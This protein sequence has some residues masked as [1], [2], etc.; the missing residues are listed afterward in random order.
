INIYRLL[1][2][3]GRSAGPWIGAP[4]SLSVQSA[5]PGEAV[6]FVPDRTTDFAAAEVSGESQFLAVKE[7][8]FVE[9][10]HQGEAIAEVAL[11]YVT[12]KQ[13]SFSTLVVVPVVKTD[14]GILVGL[15]VRNLAAVQSFTG[16]SAIL[17]VPAWRL[18]RS[19]TNVTELPAFLTS[20]LPQEFALSVLNTWELGGPYFCSP[21]VTPEVVHPFVV[22]VK[23]SDMASSVL[24]FVKFEDLRSNLDQ[25]C[26]AHL[27]I[28]AHRL[29]H[30]THAQIATREE[31]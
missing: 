24:R 25:I 29:I 10:N 3:L 1:E 6:S 12:P 14:D 31:E 30:A 16:S 17:S 18:E 22:E 27:L 9:R 28:A 26:D 11:E 5:S 8:T 13:L 20:A 7:A 4:L 15:E 2:Q 23:A 19:I 21:G